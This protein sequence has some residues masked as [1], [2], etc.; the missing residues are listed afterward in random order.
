MILTT[1]FSHTVVNKLELTLAP[2][3]PEQQQKPAILDLWR[4][5]KLFPYL[6]WKHATRPQFLHY[7][8]QTQPLN[9]WLQ[10]LDG[11]DEAWGTDQ[12]CL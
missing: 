3:A 4:A 10:L 5:E 2:S 6:C 12:S 7:H 11:R 9:P 8:L 1:Y